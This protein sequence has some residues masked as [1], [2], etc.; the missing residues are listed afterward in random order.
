MSKIIY[1]LANYFQK[2]RL[3]ILFLSLTITIVIVGYSIF[4]YE[5]KRIIKDE[6]KYLNFVGTFEESNIIR[7]FN[8]TMNIA[9]AIHSSDLFY[10]NFR[11]YLSNPSKLE[12]QA[13]VRDYIKTVIKDK[14][15][16]SGFIIDTL[17]KTIFNYGDRIYELTQQSKKWILNSSNQKK[18]TLSDIYLDE[19]TNTPYFELIIAIDGDEIQNENVLGYLVFLINAREDLFARLNTW[20]GLSGSSETLIFKI[21]EDELIYLNDA[22]HL[23]NFAMRLR[24]KIGAEEIPGKR[25]STFEKGVVEGI[26]YRGEKVLAYTAYIPQMDWYLVVKVDKKEVLLAINKAFYVAAGSTVI[27]LILFGTVFGIIWRKQ[28]IVQLEKEL[29]LQSDRTILSQ[30][31]ETLSKFANDA[32]ILADKELKIVEANEKTVEMYGYSYPELLNLPLLVLRAPEERLS[33]KNIVE[34][35]RSM[36]GMVYETLH[37]KKDGTKF[38]VEV[39]AKTI[40]IGGK[41]Y[42]IEICRDITE[43]KKFEK[44]LNESRIKAEES[45]RL[46]SNFLS[47]MSHEVRTPLNI[48]LGVIDILKEAVKNEILPAKDHFFDMISRNSS[49]LMT[50]I[51]DMIDI[52][53]IE[54][55][56]MSLS[57]TVRNAESMLMDLK[58][59]FEMETF[60]KG[61]QIIEKYDAPNAYIKIDE[62]RFHQVISNIISNAIKFTQ[63][64]GITLSTKIIDEEVNI[65]VKDTGI[66]ISDKFKNHLFKLFRQADEGF[67]RNFEGAGLGLAI[68]NR[69]ANLM[70]GRINVESE[71]NKGSTFTVIFPKVESRFLIAPDNSNAHRSS[72]YII[73]SKPTVLIVDDNKDSRFFVEVILNKLGLNYHTASDSKTAVQI[74]NQFDID[75]I[76]IDINLYGDIDGEKLFDII[77]FEL[78]FDS[79]PIVAVTGHSKNGDRERFLARGFNDYISKPFTMETLSK[80]LFKYLRKEEK[81]K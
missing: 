72:Q 20:N 66:G 76:L 8:K 22:K 73:E 48:I 53:R 34:Q 77:R 36:N 6:I 54:S 60:T 62:L 27:V 39:S 10:K 13:D 14:N 44:E 45:D 42:M 79:L 32:F 11:T 26:D 67:S 33:L 81:I 55:N 57:F 24:T 64:G 63:R 65:S 59:E 46:K 75:L 80:I 56:E 70:G 18:V 47:M 9:H 61:L 28:R 17:G 52:S 35:I 25:I 7:W 78:L 58:A 37:L 23:G 30:K 31:Y 43:R 2:N 19:D 12:N 21:V 29:A 38:F 51:N 41:E 1:S 69:F 15:L 4:S 40:E 71:I 68:A 16:I 49:R 3:L 5:S 74:L 50:L